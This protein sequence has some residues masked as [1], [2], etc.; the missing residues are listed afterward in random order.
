MVENF[1]AF[2]QALDGVD[3]LRAPAAIEAFVA[4]VL[5]DGVVDGRLDTGLLCGGRQGFVVF[6]QFI[7]NCK[8]TV[9]FLEF[10]ELGDVI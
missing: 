1:L 9:V 7:T 2:L 5:E 8:A 3:V 6:D 4:V 10:A